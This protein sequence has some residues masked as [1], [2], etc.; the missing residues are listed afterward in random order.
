MGEVWLAEQQQP[1]R[2]RV[3]LK[4]IKSGLDSRQVVARFESER[5]ALALM[6]HPSIAKVFDVGTTE[7]GRPW[8]AMEYVDGEPIT[9]YCDRRQLSTG[10]RLTLFLSVC[11]GTRHAHQKG[12][13]HRDL[14]PSNVLVSETDG[15]AT[16][17][18]IDFG[19]AKA[20]HQRLTE[21]TFFTQFGTVMGTPEYMSP[22]QAG[23][24]GVDVDTRT[25]VY[26]L[27][28][29]L[30]ELL[31][32]ALPF[33]PYG[34]RSAGFEEICRRIREEEPPKPSTRLTTHGDAG[35]ESARNRGTDE[36]SLERQLRGD[37]DWITMKALEKERGRRYGS[38]EELASDIQHHLADEPVMAGPP[39]AAYRL[40]KFF[41]RHRVVVVAASLVLLALI[42][43]IVGTTYGLLRARQ[44]EIKA[45][46]DAETARQV[47]DFLVEMLEGADPAQSRGEE[48]TVRQALDAGAKTIERDLAGQ[49]RIQAKL[50]YT[51][52][53]VYASLGMWDEAEVLLDASLEKMKR[54]LGE[55][56]L[57]TL[58]ALQ[59]R[60]NVHRFRN[61]FDIAADAYRRVYEARSELLGAGHADTV[62]AQQFLGYL[63]MRL[64]RFEEAEELL[65]D[66]MEIE[67]RERGVHQAGWLKAATARA[68][69][70]RERQQ[71]SEAARL[72]ERVL[73]NMDG[74]WEED[75]P[76]V[77]VTRRLLAMCY[78]RV[79]RFDEAVALHSRVI[80]VQRRVLGDDHFQTLQSMHN[81]GITLILQGNFAEAVA[82]YEE[83]LAGRRRALGEDDTQTLW[84]AKNLSGCLYYDG[85]LEESV[86]VAREVLKVIDERL[87][88]EHRLRVF[89]LQFAANSLI[90]AGR[91]EEAR[92]MV[93]ELLADPSS[94]TD[95]PNAEAKFLYA[96]LLLTGQ[97][98]D[99]GSAE[100]A[101][102]LA[103]EARDA[104]L[105]EAPIFW[106]T[107]ALA[108]FRNGKALEA[109]EA[110]QRALSSL[111]DNRPEAREEFQARLAEYGGP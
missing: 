90:D 25:D 21:K 101:L 86:R 88:G 85:R 34:L 35:S 50:E 27:G 67:E 95:A 98:P 71:Y 51:M 23:T 37:L 49:P 87:E 109:R 12:I 102:Q 93:E 30:Y 46:A 6:D 74:V 52:G 15:V 82:V 42:V 5:Q 91:G 106:D 105:F 24:S 53:R 38:V 28:V 96:R 99:V 69:V 97:L 19:V 9:T 92:S 3:A 77:S 76:R 54:L 18:I 11:A 1:V 13:V 29:L 61:Q 2:R 94:L 79:E 62:D 58:A 8:F 45:R 26:S 110:Q 36:R 66:A 80:E 78:E 55:D 57:Q 84:S 43:G 100:L 39:S 33:D 63:M 83:V 17:K 72:L 10:D 103:R 65:D 73:K 32:G 47:S 56:D 44:A 75:L 111:P 60:G 59:V 31:V 70:H 16:P 4:L 7:R 108:Y 48:I 22:E 64:T 81:L 20:L 68:A 107:L 104:D 41:R 40:H 89:F 14:K